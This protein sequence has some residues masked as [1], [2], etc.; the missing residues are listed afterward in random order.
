MSATFPVSLLCCSC[1]RYSSYGRHFTK[2][3]RLKIVARKLATF[4]ENGDLVRPQPVAPSCMTVGL[5]PCTQQ[6][7]CGLSGKGRA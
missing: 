1:C 6:G 2:E 4:L 3:D 5:H 7:V